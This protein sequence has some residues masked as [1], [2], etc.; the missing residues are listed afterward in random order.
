MVGSQLNVKLSGVLEYEFLAR[1]SPEVLRQLENVTR[2]EQG[3]RPS[4]GWD[5]KLLAGKEAAAL[6]K[7][8]PV[9]AVGS[10]RPCRPRC[11]DTERFG[12]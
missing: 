8:T 1:L 9:P 10:T 12:K 11:R 7:A 3:R 2:R 6:R 4:M 5:W